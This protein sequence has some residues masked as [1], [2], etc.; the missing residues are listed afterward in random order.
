VFA[1]L[2]EELLIA[3]LIMTVFADVIGTTFWV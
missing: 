1:L 2:A 3:V